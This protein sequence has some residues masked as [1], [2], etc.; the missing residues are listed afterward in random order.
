MFFRD[1]GV[2]T[3]ISAFYLSS[4]DLYFIIKIKM[5]LI[6]LI[7]NHDVIR[8]IKY[9][10]AYENIGSKSRILPPTSEEWFSMSHD[11]IGQSPPSFSCYLNQGVDYQ[12]WVEYSVL[13]LSFV[14]LIT[15]SFALH[16]L[17]FYI[18]IK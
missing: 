16:G 10:N 14:C 3:L 9:I 17:L 18:S 7:Y 8:N 5:A 11:E 13:D 6:L 4:S 12:T 2:E 1:L 15:S